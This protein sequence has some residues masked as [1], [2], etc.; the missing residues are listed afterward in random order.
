L[1]FLRFS[2]VVLF[3]GDVL[4][5]TAEASTGLFSGLFLR[6]SFVTTCFHGDLVRLGDKGTSGAPSW[7]SMT[8]ASPFSANA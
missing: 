5:S 1:V 6:F 2:F 7:A 4:I 8:H 3:L